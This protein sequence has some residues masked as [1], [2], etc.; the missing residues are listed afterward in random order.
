MRRE[1]A[2]CMVQRVQFTFPKGT[3]LTVV[4]EAIRREWPDLDV[5]IKRDRASTDTKIAGTRFRRVG[6]G[7]RGLRIIVRERG[8]II[9]D[10]S[11]AETYRQ[12]Q[13]VV[14]WMN[15]RARG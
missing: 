8:A 3:R 6:K 15:G 5:Q 14:D 13:E 2:D 7:R 1:R 10:H 11:N 12:T 9:L 4:A